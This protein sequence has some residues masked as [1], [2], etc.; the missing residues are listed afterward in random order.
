MSWLQPV[1]GHRVRTAVDIQDGQTC[2]GHGKVGCTEAA[3][4]AQTRFADLRELSE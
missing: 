2:L 3:M 1:N 4:A